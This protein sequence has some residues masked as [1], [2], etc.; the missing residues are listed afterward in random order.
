L[1]L[2]KI[3]IRNKGRSFSEMLTVR[4]FYCL[5]NPGF[6][7]YPGVFRELLIIEGS[8]FPSAVIIRNKE[9]I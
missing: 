1:S 9:S 7:M 8:S 3:F 5:K 2:I 4:L 6:P